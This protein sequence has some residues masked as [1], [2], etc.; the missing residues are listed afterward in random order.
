MHVNQ[1][2]LVGPMVNL[3]FSALHDKLKKDTKVRS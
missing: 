1:P 3:L 2:V